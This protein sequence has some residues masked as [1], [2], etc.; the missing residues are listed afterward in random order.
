MS[1]GARSVPSMEILLIPGFWLDASSWAA[2]APRLAEAGH[3][4]RA[5]TLP[6]LEARAADRSRIGAHEHVDAIVAAIDAARARV[7]LVGHSGGGPLAYAAASRRPERVA[8]IVYVDSGPLES[9]RAINPALPAKGSDVPLPAWDEFDEASLRDLDAA[10]RERFRARAVPEPARVT[11]DPLEIG[12][13]RVRLVPATVIACETSGEELRRL[14]ASGHPYTAELARA[15]DCEI[16]DLPTGHW[17]QL[18]RPD[19]LAR[20]LLAAVDR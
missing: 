7:V 11:R 13:D 8:R 4:V 12:D 1:G 18:T 14:I 3:A 2:V 6:G 10:R 5:L 19:D 17:P 20:L 9:G 15:A 16:V